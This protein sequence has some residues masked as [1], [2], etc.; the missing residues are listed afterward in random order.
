MER[1]GDFPPYLN[2]I[3]ILNLILKNLILKNLILK[4]LILKTSTNKPTK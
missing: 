3:L 1:G 2:L 4:N